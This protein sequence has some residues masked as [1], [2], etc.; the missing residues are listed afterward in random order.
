MTNNPNV[1]IPTSQEIVDYY[2]FSKLDYQLYNLSFSNISMHFGL[3]DE[4]TEN[5]R[6]ALLNENK[7]LAELANITPNDHVIDLGCGYG[8]TAI[9]LAKN[10]GCRVVGITIS[11]KQVLEA[12]RAAKQ[13]RVSHLVD[14]SVMDF[15]KTNFSK[16]TFNVAIAIESVSHSS[17][18]PKVLKEIHRILKSDGRFAIADG[19]FAKDTKTLSPREHEIAKICFEGVHVPP[20]AERSEFENWLKE[21]GFV[22]V[23]WFDKTKNILKISQKISGFAKMILPISKI[24][25]FLGFRS[26]DTSHI[27]AFINQYYAWNGNLG[28]YGIFSAKKS[29]GDGQ[30]FLIK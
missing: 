30:E 28:V 17:D 14:F 7:V 9:W 6:Q 19:Y 3:W 23:K 22:E 15:H 18:K 25:G 10:I 29:S 26:L 2:D 16:N 4:T 21:N 8:T 20:L 24:L 1:K 27:K 13:H 11:K 5:H 12:K